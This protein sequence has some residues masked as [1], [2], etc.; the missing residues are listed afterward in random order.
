MSESEIVKKTQDS[1]LK[2]EQTKQEA[3]RVLKELSLASSK[4]RKSTKSENSKHETLR[5][6]RKENNSNHSE[7]KNNQLEPKALF[8]YNINL[9]L[10]LKIILIDDDQVMRKSKNGLGL[11][12]G[13]GEE[14]SLFN[15][16]YLLHTLPATQSIKKVLINFVRYMKNGSNQKKGKKS[17]NGTYTEETLLP[18]LI[19]LFNI[20]LPICLLYPSERVQY[21]QTFLDNANCNLEPHEIYPCQHLLRLF[22]KLHLILPMLDSSSE[23]KTGTEI[24]KPYLFHLEK[25]INDLI[26]YLQV[27]RQ[28]CFRIRYKESA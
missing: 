25:L 27:N 20:A 19:R 18:S 10:T 8:P 26:F 11:D 6:K 12:D 13:N 22:T 21:K 3:K 15:A 14:K 9:P 5:K 1:Y 17:E 28:K 2:A 23:E 24:E 16:V 4:K 7:S